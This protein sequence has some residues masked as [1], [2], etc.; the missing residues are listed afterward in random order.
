MVACITKKSTCEMNGGVSLFSKI[1]H[2]Q[3]RPMFTA[4]RLLLQCIKNQLSA[5]SKF[6]IENEPKIQWV[7]K[8]QYSV[9]KAVG[10]PTCIRKY[11]CFTT[12]QL[13]SFLLAKQSTSSLSPNGIIKT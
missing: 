7:M 8:Q 2:Q 13:E 10:W 4:G 9:C 11:I 3:R 12:I 1:M 5:N 6:C